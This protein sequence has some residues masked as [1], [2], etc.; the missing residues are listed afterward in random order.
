MSIEILA[1]GNEILSGNTLNTNAAF[2]STQLMLEGWRVSRHTVVPDEENVITQEIQNAFKRT[3]CVIATGGLGP[4]LDDI[5]AASVAPLFKNSPQEIPNRV[6][7]AKGLCFEDEGKVLILLPGIPQEM[8]VML[9]EEV[10]SRLQRLFPHKQ[11]RHQASLHFCLLKEQELDPLLRLLKEEF[12][13]L[14]FG[15]YPAFGTLSVMLH[16]TDLKTIEAAKQQIQ[17]QF[18]SHLIPEKSIEETIHHW[19]TT[20]QKTLALA[21]SCTGGLLAAHLTALP[22]ASNYFLGS[23]VTYSN[24]L[25]EQLLG[26][27]PAT[28]H[29]KGAVSSET[30]SEMLHGL[31]TTTGA[32]YGIAVSGIAGPAGGSVEQPVGT[33]WYALS[34]KGQA[35]FIGTFLAKGSRE[36][37]ILQTTKKLLGILW[38]QILSNNKILN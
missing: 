35:P 28:L 12:P 30:V 11:Q 31:F 8:R 19:F 18:T 21:E 38:Q 16:S 22:G 2:I 36:T 13:Q 26:V 15:I 3:A 27:S 23:L 17:K 29:A 9:E 6:G 20:H 25:K 1:I 10:L 5:T 37:I 4:T 24:Q 7:S 33:I 34:A 32:D 14:E